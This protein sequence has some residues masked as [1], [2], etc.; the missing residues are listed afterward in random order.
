MFVFE[1]SICKDAVKEN[2]VRGGCV[3]MCALLKVARTINSEWAIV[4]IDKRPI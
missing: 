2:L 1:R 3:M 4:G